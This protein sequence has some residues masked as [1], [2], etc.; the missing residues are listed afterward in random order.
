M[1]KKKNPFEG[2][3]RIVSMRASNAASMPM[4]MADCISDSRALLTRSYA[5]SEIDV[6]VLEAKLSVSGQGKG[7]QPYS[8]ARLAGSMLSRGSPPQQSRRSSGTNRSV[9][10]ETERGRV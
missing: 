6:A 2:R 10:A 3:W 9:I 7:W 5:R 4:A 8:L 1:A